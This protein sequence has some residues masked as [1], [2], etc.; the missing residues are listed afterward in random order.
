MPPAKGTRARAALAGA[1]WD[2]S[3]GAVDAFM[4]VTLTRDAPEVPAQ[5]R[6]DQVDAALLVPV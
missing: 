4:V 1:G 6:E 2:L 3:L 5:L